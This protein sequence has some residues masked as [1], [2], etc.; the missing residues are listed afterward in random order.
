MKNQEVKLVTI[1]EVEQV[2]TASEELAKRYQEAYQANLDRL[3]K[4]IQRRRK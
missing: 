1:D 4:K 2:L 3:N